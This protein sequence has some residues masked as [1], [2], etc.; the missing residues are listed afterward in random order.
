MTFSCTATWQSTVTFVR[1]SGCTS[2]I[3]GNCLYAY[4]RETVE[5]DGQ[6]NTQP[7]PLGATLVSCR[8]HR[9]HAGA[10]AVVAGVIV[11]A[12]LLPLAFVLSASRI[13]PRG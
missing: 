12:L 3:G 2:T 1:P 11:G 10:G 6:C 4:E 8:D 5:R 7:V 13:A 9:D